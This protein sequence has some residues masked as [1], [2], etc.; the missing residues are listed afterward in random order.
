MGSWSHKNKNITINTDA[1]V[2]PNPTHPP[3]PPAPPPASQ[4][5]AATSHRLFIKALIICYSSIWAKGRLG[6]ME[7]FTCRKAFM[8]CAQAPRRWFMSVA[9]E[10]RGHYNSQSS[11]Y[12]ADRVFNKAT[13]IWPSWHGLVSGAFCHFYMRIS[14][15][16]PHGKIALF[17]P[18]GFSL[19]FQQSIRGLFCWGWW[20]PE[21]HNSESKTTTATHTRPHNNGPA[22]RTALQIKSASKILAPVFLWLMF[23]WLSGRVALFSPNEAGRV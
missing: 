16:S 4:L 13:H 8:S 12:S 7:R 19:S 5:P 3:P 14:C 18:A 20:T 10:G 2:V 17:I 15:S 6:S 1:A 9:E 11:R 23:Q 22:L 21:R